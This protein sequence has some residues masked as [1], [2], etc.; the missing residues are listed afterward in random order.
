MSEGILIAIIGVIGTVLGAVVSSILQH[1]RDTRINRSWI[2]ISAISGMFAGLAVGII[3]TQQ[4]TPLTEITPT[5]PSQISAQITPPT[6]SPTTVP[7]ISPTTVPT[8]SPTTVPTISP[9]TVPTISPTTVPTVNTYTVKIYNCDDKCSLYINNVF[10]VGVNYGEQSQW[11]DIKPFLTAIQNT[12]KLHVFNEELGYTY[13]IHV[14]KD[15]SDL[16]I[17]GCGEVASYGCQNNF[18]DTSPRERVYSYMIIK[19]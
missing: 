5:Y 15:D 1:P 14:T 11:I 12:I 13:G 19:P 7:T 10:V 17:D 4:K 2:V 3:I 6:I 8:I 9:T 18:Y 16:I